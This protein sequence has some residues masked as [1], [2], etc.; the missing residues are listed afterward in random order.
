[1]T[2]RKRTGLFLAVAGV[3]ALGASAVLWRQGAPDLA[4]N[5]ASSA[6]LED[7]LKRVHAEL[8]QVSLKAR[9]PTAR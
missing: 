9:A 3:L 8:V 4:K 5:A 6:A 7:S 2:G 1:M